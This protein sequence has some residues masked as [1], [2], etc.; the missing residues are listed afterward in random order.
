MKIA[1]WLFASFA[2]LGRLASAQAVPPIDPEQYESWGQLL[3][4]LQ[5]YGFT[6]SDDVELDPDGRT[7]TL[8]YYWVGPV[9]LDRRD[10]KIGSVARMRGNGCK[11][12]HDCDHP[13]GP[14]NT[15]ELDE[16]LE[17]TIEDT[18]TSRTLDE[19]GMSLTQGMRD[20]ITAKG[21]ASA[22]GLA[23]VK[24]ENEIEFK[25][26]L[27]TSLRHARETIKSKVSGQTVSERV[28]DNITIEMCYQK[29]IYVGYVFSYVLETNVIVGVTIQLERK[30]DYWELK[31]L[32]VTRVAL[33]ARTRVEGPAPGWWTED[34]LFCECASPTSM[35]LDPKPLDDALDTF[36][37]GEYAINVSTDEPATVEFFGSSVGDFVAT[38]E[39]NAPEK[40]AV[41]A[42]N[43]RPAS[44]SVDL[45]DTTRATYFTRNHADQPDA[46]T[47]KFAKRSGDASTPT[48]DGPLTVIPSKQGDASI[49]SVLV[50]NL[51][52]SKADPS[53]PPAEVLFY[54][55]DELVAALDPKFQVTEKNGTRHLGGNVRVL[56]AAKFKDDRPLD[57]KVTQAGETIYEG[58]VGKDVPV[59][60]PSNPDSIEAGT[61]GPLSVNPNVKVDPNEAKVGQTVSIT[62]A[63]TDS[64]QKQLEDAGYPVETIRI[65]LFDPKGNKIGEGPATGEVTGQAVADQPGRYVVRAVVG[66]STNAADLKAAHERI[67]K[68]SDA[69]IKRVPQEW[70][71]F[72]DSLRAMEKQTHERVDRKAGAFVKP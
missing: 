36:G 22:F 20:K 27:T 54:K 67:T 17:T 65:T 37:G 12:P 14:A 71:S 69:A 35:I 13:C 52:P 50:S 41:A 51:P 53:A 59:R 39:R 33:P 44:T 64:Q 9:E 32:E 29:L 26:E 25:S 57:M 56:D 55:D 45:T 6:P 63:L 47:L 1:L 70:K 43:D 42:L 10:A 68:T 2:L 8:R 23:G 4:D 62:A 72:A 46:F 19:I 60:D 18:Q 11:R 24:L 40:L 34:K 49:P 58:A 61:T 38:Q 30:D 7:L 3:T 21:N 16:T 5:A 31:S 66:P 15:T 48:I 28:K